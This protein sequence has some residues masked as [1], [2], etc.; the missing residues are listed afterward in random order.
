[1]IVKNWIRSKLKKS[2]DVLVQQT[3]AC[4][5]VLWQFGYECEDFRVDSKPFSFLLVSCCVR[6]DPEN[7]SVG[8]TE[9][10]ENVTY[11]I[12]CFHLEKK[13]H[14]VYLL[15]YLSWWIWNIAATNTKTIQHFLSPWFV[16]LK[17][18]SYRD[19]IPL[20]ELQGGANLSGVINIHDVVHHEHG[21]HR[22][23]ERGD[24]FHHDHLIHRHHEL[25]HRQRD[26]SC[27]NI[28]HKVQLDR[29][30]SCFKDNVI[31]EKSV[32]IKT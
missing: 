32:W 25:S 12:H 15:L 27:G 30:T 4:S 26:V 2:E 1:M 22:I 11:F 28:R 16:L 23:R 5:V 20:K 9:N 21:G 14:C 10:L 31:R 17:R 6:V 3:S 13:H 8:R 19:K 24:S 29:V 7:T 18:T